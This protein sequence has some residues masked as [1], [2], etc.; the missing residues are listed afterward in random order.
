MEYKILEKQDLALMLDF[1]DDENT[2]YDEAV[3]KD[4]V[5]APYYGDF[6]GC[7]PVV[8]W[9]SETEVLYDDSLLMFEKFKDQGVTTKLYLRRGM[10]HTWLIIPA[11][12]ESKKDLKILGQ[13]IRLAFDGA[14][15]T[16]SEPI[17]L[18]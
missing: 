18:G 14:L 1:V 15:E 11:L 7:T 16:V 4:P 12:S 13:D 9:A 8:L 6:R 5:A 3:L 10:L 2:K 17:R